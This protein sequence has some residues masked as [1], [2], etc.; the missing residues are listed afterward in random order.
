MG[1]TARGMA[2]A[3]VALAL[4]SSAPAA[5]PDP[6]RV[7]TLAELPH[8]ADELMVDAGVPGL[9]VVV[10]TRD[11]VVVARGFGR[12][13][14][15]AGLP[16]GP[17][18]LFALGSASK[19]F[20]AFTLALL[21]EEGRIDLDRPLRAVL[22]ELRL[23]DL[24]ASAAVTPR[25]L[26]AHRT[27]LG[28]HDLVWYRSPGG[29]EELVS[30]IQHLELSAPFRSTFLYS[31]L[32][33]IAAGRA[34]ERAGGASYEELVSRR[35]FA[36]L[37][38]GR[39]VC[40]PVPAGD[41]DVARPYALGADGKVAPMPPYDGWA[42]TPAAG[43]SS[44]AEDLARWLQLL[45]GGGAIGDTRLLSEAA[46][47]GLYTPQVAAPVLGPRELPLVTY[48]LGWFVQPYRGHLLAWHGGVLDGFS[49]LVSL[50]P[51]D[52]LGVAVL[53]NRTGH[54]AHEVLARWLWDRFLGLPEGN[55]RGWAEAERRVAEE[56]R[57]AA[58]AE[59]RSRQDEGGPASLPLAGYAG[60]YL[61][62]AYGELRVE[63]GAEGLLVSL[64][65]VS[66]PLEHFAGETFL[67]RFALDELD[68]EIGVA[69]QL[70]ADGAASSL[71]LKVEDGAPPLT[72]VRL[73]G[74]G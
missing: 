70:G 48:G 68:Q 24:A 74:A 57:A 32:G 72:F 35:V 46:V 67:F 42:M 44:T 10:V 49:C 21:A 59:R 56:R 13:D 20:T 6:R 33:Y 38:M 54:R 65:G 2:P 4:L 55:W 45:L 26:L 50:F 12:R 61:H 62:P 9:A 66:A 51:A 43:I 11:E 58:A 60:R 16:V 47:R 25:D 37:G 64:H 31:N 7:E 8:L 19:A 15:E 22:P 40:G 41:G 17:K 34:A 29:R 14:L 63:A 5:E 71:L 23:A 1:K 18:T 39:S 53:T 52:N 36:P 3:V 30:A 28:R 69:F 73:P 27:G